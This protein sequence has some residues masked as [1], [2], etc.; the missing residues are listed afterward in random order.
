MPQFAVG[1]L[2][3]R[4]MKRNEKLRAPKPRKHLL[5]W[6]MNESATDLQARIAA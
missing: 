5:W 4:R 3:N 6:D 1:P 2:P